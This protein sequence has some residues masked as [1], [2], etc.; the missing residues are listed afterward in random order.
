MPAK[1]SGR[2]VGFMLLIAFCVYGGGSILATSATG[3][4]VVLADVV[5]SQNRL[6]AGVLLMLLNS[7]VVITIG[8]AA[9]PVLKRHHPATATAYLLTRGFESALLA[10]GSVLLLT[11]VPL[12]DEFDATGDQGLAVM[13][14]VTQETS[15]HAYWVAMI[16][17]SLGSLLFC[18]AL[19]RARLVP[20][21][22]AAWGSAGY[23]LL[24]TG[25]VLE[26]F[27][28]E[29]GVLLG[30][31]G[32]LFEATVGVL[33]VVKGFPEAQ[34]QDL[35]AASVLVPKARLRTSASV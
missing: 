31:P 27:G 18:R 34:H 17:L 5:G 29:V 3:T 7:A 32:G 28:H 33:L 10:V 23:A 2:I 9:Y 30:A 11:M 14:R 12:A 6:T 35:A 26:L 20:R 24:A 19:F 21:A 15:L 25:G 1:V 8:V 13:A 22:L 4:P 16:G